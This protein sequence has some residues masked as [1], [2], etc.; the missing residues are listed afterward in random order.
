MTFELDLGMD[1]AGTVL[2][3]FWYL[4][5]FGRGA[6]FLVFTALPL[7]ASLRSSPH[8]SAKPLDAF[9]FVALMEVTWLSRVESILNYL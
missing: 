1:P 5:T 6:D 2:F 4:S 3:K 8:L 7:P 9:E